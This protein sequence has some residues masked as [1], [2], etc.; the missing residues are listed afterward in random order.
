MAQDGQECLGVAERFVHPDLDG[1]RIEGAAAAALGRP[2]DE[3]EKRFELLAW[4]AVGL[5]D[6]LQRRLADDA[7]VQTV[8]HF[9]IKPLAAAEMVVDSREVRACHLADFL[10][11]DGGESLLRRELFGAIE[12]LLARRAAIF[13]LF[14]V[15]FHLLKSSLSYGSLSEGAVSRMAD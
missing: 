13:A 4:R 5:C 10:A 1:A 8:E 2:E 12:Q 15:V 7:V 3:M 14:C 9:L 11:R 6:F